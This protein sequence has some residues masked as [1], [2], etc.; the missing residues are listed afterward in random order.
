[1]RAAGIRKMQ[2]DRIPS[3]LYFESKIVRIIRKIPSKCCFAGI[4]VLLSK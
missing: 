1:M 2:N 4:F 3:D